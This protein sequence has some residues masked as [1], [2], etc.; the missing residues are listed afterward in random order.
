MRPFA[1]SIP[2]LV[3]ALMVRFCIN[4][5]VG[6][7][8]QLGAE[9][10][11]TGLRA[12]G[13]SLI[14]ITLYVATA[15]S[16]FVVYSGRIWHGLPLIILAVLGLVGGGASLLLPETKGKP[17]PQTIADGEQLI[18][19]NTLYGKPEKEQQETDVIFLENKTSIEFG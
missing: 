19:E 10:L 9:M 12:M 6:V 16:P 3:L 17:M 11:P 2:Q 7:Q 5:S 13:T 4:M 1:R 14:H 8:I 15:I 18:R